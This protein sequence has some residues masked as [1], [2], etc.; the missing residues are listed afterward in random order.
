LSPHSCLLTVE[1]K[2][3]VVEVE[4]SFGRWLQRRR[5][6]LDL[7]QEALAQR[8]GCAAETLRKI[9]ADVRRPSRQIAE[10]LA[11]ELEIPEAERAAFIKA[12]RAELAVDRLAHPTQDLPQIAFGPP[13]SSNKPVTNLPAPLT[14]F[15]GREKEQR[16]VIDLITKHRLVTLTGP[17]GVGK[18]RLS[19]K[20]GEQILESYPDGVWL[21]ELAPILEPLLVPRATAIAIG[22]RDEPQRPV[23]DMLSDYLRKKQ[24]LIILD[25][26]EHLLDACAELVDT[27]LKHCASL[28]ILT[29]SREALGILGEAVYSVPSLELPDT[30]QVVETFRGYE[31]VRLFEERAQ[32][33]RTNF[34]LTIENAS[35]VAKICNSLDGIP[36]AIELAAAQVKVF[37]PEEIAFQLQEGFGLLTTGNRTALPRHQTLRSAID[38]SYALLSLAEQT[39]FRRLSVFVDGCTLDAAQSICSD[40]NIKSE[41]IL[42]LLIQLINKSLVMMIETHRGTRYHLLETIRQY[43][44]EKLL[45]SG[46]EGSIREQHLHY[47]L[48]LSE[49]IEQE[50]V[51]PQQSDWFALTNDERNNLYSA[52]EQASHTDVEAGMYI[53]GRLGLFWEYFDIREGRRWLT[54]LLMKPESKSYPHARAKALFT[55]SRL[56]HDSEQFNEAP[57]AA[58]ESLALFR[59]LGDPYGEVD[60]LFVLASLTILGSAPDPERGVELAR[61]ALTRAESL[62]DI[63]RQA[64]SLHILGWDHRDFERDFAYWEQAAALY[65]Q[66]G[67]WIGLAEC[68]GDLG[69]FLLL[70]GQLDTAQKYLDESKSLFEKLNPRFIDS[71]LRSFG[72]IAL[73]RGDYEQARRYFQQEA[74]INK[75]SSRMGYLWAMVRLGFAELLAGNIVE[76]RRIF[77]E[78]ARSFQND[79]NQI[80]VVFT[81]EGMSSLYVT[82][83]KPIVAAR[84][85]GWT[86]ATREK[87]GDSRPKVEQADMDKIIAA[88][89]AK[90]GEVAYA[91]AYNEGSGLT[92][93]EAVELALGDS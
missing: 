48:K 75:L 46:E 92:L 40:A 11:E 14:T 83:D 74:E 26:C 2:E 30:Q 10:R 85:I 36:L 1:A 87:I 66:A 27:L 15:I 38:W 89:I 45:E 91:E 78:V 86:D 72:Q 67:H 25:N 52:L 9:E 21:V 4:I 63:R 51:G 37:S 93:D 32:L 34:S 29:T 35:F 47:F 12:A 28:K 73:M 39:L 5:K 50:L 6:A 64:I 81:L 20:V 43:G 18:T 80:G 62:G 7:T 71:L 79:G 70:D 23:I 57:I 69:F 24:M 84:L 41:A 65:R 33:A 49:Q 77:T 76:A 68:L 42:D 17:G 90:I 59:A 58:E 53:S 22:L 56:L 19:F 44:Y 88:C 82:V 8:V 3:V 55:Q 31:S 61:Q 16:D 54:E 60:S 13:P